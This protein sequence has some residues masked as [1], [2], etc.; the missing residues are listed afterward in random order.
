MSLI[1]G[2]PLLDYPSF[3]VDDLDMSS[4]KL[5]AACDIDFADLNDSLLI[6]DQDHAVTDLSPLRCNIAFLVNRKCRICSYRI[7]FRC[8]FLM[9]GVCDARA[10]ASDNM[11]RL[12][13]VFSALIVYS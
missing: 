12:V 1:C 2:I 13:D 11:D 3:L 5:L 10:E 8:R 4:F 6:S 7:A 9:Q